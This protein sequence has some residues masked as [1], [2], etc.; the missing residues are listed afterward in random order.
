MQTI[1]T[2][3]HLYS[4]PISLHGYE[5]SAVKG[6]QFLHILISLICAET[7]FNFNFSAPTKYI[8][9]EE[10]SWAQGKYVY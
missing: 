9:M 10:R 5:G 2:S 3:L 6:L 4:I 1:F 8:W 7:N